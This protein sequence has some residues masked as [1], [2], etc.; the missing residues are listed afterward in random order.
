M[1]DSPSRSDNHHCSVFE[2]TLRQATIGRTTLNDE[3]VRRR[4][5]YLTTHNTHTPGEIRIRNPSKRAV[6]DPRLRP[7]GHW[8][9]QYFNVHFITYLLT[10]LLTP[11]CSPS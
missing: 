5:L 3:H 10:Y 4:D 2:S 8:D 11:W 9:W 1:H 7:R 6:A